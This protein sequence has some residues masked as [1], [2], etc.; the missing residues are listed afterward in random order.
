MP[1]KADTAITH[2]IG[3][4]TGKNTLHVI[5]LDEKGAIVLREKVSRTRITARFVNVPPC[6]IGIEAGMASHHI[7]RELVALGH[8]VKQVPPAYSKPFRQGHKN[9]FRD[10]HAVAQAAERPST[11]CV[12]IKTDGQL[13][14][15]ALHRVRSR[16]VGNRTAVINQIRGFLLEH[17]IPV[18]QGHRFLRQQLPQL[19]ATRTDVLSPRM[20][21]IIGDLMADWT[22]FD[23]RI[24]GVTDEIEALARADE[25]CQH[26]T[27]GSIDRLVF[28][29]LYGL[30]PGVL[31]ALAIV[32]PETVIRWH[33][34][35]FRSYWRWRSRPLGGRPRAP[36]DVRQLIRDIS[37][38][39]PFWGAPRI[40]GELLKLGIDVG[41][42]TVAK[43]MVRGR[44]PPSQGWKTFL[45]NHADGI[46]SMDLFVVPTISFQ[47]LYGLLILQHG[48]R[49]ILWLGATTHPSAE[50]ISRQLTEACGGEQGPR[51][52]VRDRDSV[53][54]N[55]FIRRLRAMGIRDRPTAPRSLWQNGYCERLIGSIRQEC[56]DHVVVFGERHLRYLLRSYANYYNQTRTHLSLNKDSPVSR[57]VETIG[58]EMRKV[59]PS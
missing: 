14:L 28:A 41:Q 2:T 8:E 21:R 45:R 13:D 53:Y 36:P 48:R 50:W 16:L 25:G 49:E 24:E 56:L 55:V 19:L 30:A 23:E 1:S 52:L 33:R 35:G 9:D 39:N 31:N 51:Y 5:G 37:V 20:I 12:P 18:L 3:I 26:P 58:R 46:A 42:T 17:G 40:H 4:D 11:R 29:R 57:A 43:Y 27:L 10:A 7:A 47:L 6:L 59:R 54:G 34:A 15:Q 44:R 38:A 22:Y 32:R